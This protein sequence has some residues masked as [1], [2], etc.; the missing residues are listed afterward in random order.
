MRTWPSTLSFY[1][2]EKVASTMTDDSPLRARWT[3]ELMQQTNSA[4]VKQA[5]AKHTLA[6]SPFGE[7]ATGAIDYRS[8]TL[9]DGL[10]YAQFHNADFTGTVCDWAGNLS[11][12][13]VEG[14][15]FID[16]KFDGRFVTATFADCDFSGSSMSGARL[17]DRFSDTKFVR[18]KLAKAVST[19]ASFV[20]CDFSGANFRQ[21]MFTHCDFVE[22]TFAGAKFHNA[23]VAGSSFTRCNTNDGSFE[24]AITDA[25]KC[26]G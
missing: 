21:A 3:T 13:T 24:R 6:P 17:G 23:S 7:T 9:R 1:A 19:R 14:S 5:K 16:A 12:C 20:R 8:F 11:N 25:V 18:S 15:Y 26:I 4:M 2:P 10:Q 22:C